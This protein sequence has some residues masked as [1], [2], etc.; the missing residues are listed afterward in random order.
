M[1]TQLRATDR[2]VD[3]AGR[4]LTEVDRLAEDLTGE[5]L[6]GEHAYAESTPT[7]REQLRAMVRDNLSTLFAALQG[8]P[9]TLEA[10]RAAGRLK[11]TQGIPLAALLHAYR[12]AGRFVWDRLLATAV[13]EQ[14]TVQ[15]LHMASDIW[16]AVDDYS[17]AAADAS[18]P[19]SRN[20]HVATPRPGA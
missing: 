3:L 11:A 18:G 13:D 19:P 7:G 4:L 8:R 16:A 12:L 14:S 1:T 20:S 17:S 5:I 10:P 2:V 15:L 9:T 6:G